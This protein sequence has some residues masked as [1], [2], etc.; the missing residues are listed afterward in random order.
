MKH[1][2]GEIINNNMLVNKNGENIIDIISNF[3]NKNYNIIFY[4]IMPNHIHLII[5][6]KNNS[7]LKLSQIVSMFKSKISNTLKI[8][9][10][11]QKN[12][13]ERVIRD[14]KEYENIIKYIHNNPYR[15]KYNW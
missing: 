12:Y 11:W 5:E 2:L 9:N 1:L 10:L 7:S 13:Y 6:I 15:D 4:Q 14:Q 3:N 8:K